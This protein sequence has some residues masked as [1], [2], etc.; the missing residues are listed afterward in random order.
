[1]QKSE[2]SDSKHNNANETSV[3]FFEHSHISFLHTSMFPAFQEFILFQSIFTGLEAYQGL[4][5]ESWVM[6]NDSIINISVLMELK[7]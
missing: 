5:Q 7:V 6:R 3:Q 2:L 4:K 1:M